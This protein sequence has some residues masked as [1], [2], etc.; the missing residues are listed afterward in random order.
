MFPF[1]GAYE[2]NIVF[3]KNSNMQNIENLSTS[4]YPAID[5][6]QSLQLE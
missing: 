6:E 1:A 2:Y 5:T 3:F 4:V